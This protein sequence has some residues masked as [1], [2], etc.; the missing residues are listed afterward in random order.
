MIDLYSL[1]TIPFSQLDKKMNA[2]N[3]QKEQ[4][5]KELKNQK[6]KTQDPQPLIDTFGKVLDT[7]DFV[8]I[9]MIIEAL[10]DKIVIT[11]E[12]LDIYWRI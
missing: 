2:L 11:G 4:L 1:G 12:D 10:I 7:G 6:P 8:S 9:R 5:E 3:E